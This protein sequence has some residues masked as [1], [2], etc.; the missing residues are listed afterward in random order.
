MVQTEAQYKFVYM[1]VHRYIETEK[2]RLAAGQVSANT[3]NEFMLAARLCEFMLAARL[4]E[5]MLAARLKIRN[6]KHAYFFESAVW[7]KCVI[8]LFQ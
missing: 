5:F 1:A 2:S 8:C 7:I 3:E 4:C 6:V